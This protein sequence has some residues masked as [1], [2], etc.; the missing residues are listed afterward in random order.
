MKMTP[1]QHD[2]A[3]HD[4][5]FNELKSAALPSGKQCSDCTHFK[6]C[7][8]LFMCPEEN[9]MCDWSPSKFQLCTEV[10]DMETTITVKTEMYEINWHFTGAECNIFSHCTVTKIKI[11]RHSILKGC[12]L[13]SI[14]ATD[15]K[16]DVFIGS[17]NN[18]LESEADAWR[19]VRTLISFEIA[20]REARIEHSKA[21]LAAYSTFL[22]QL[23]DN[24]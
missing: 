15:H 20:V 4:Q 22:T 24:A 16:G 23:T 21:E 5:H 7:K 6:R 12:S 14:T 11:T 18:Y 8:M 2:Q 13:P 19:E 1:E 9:T 3:D 10:N 17:L